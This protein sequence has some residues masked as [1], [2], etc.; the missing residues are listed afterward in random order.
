MPTEVGALRGR[1]P[2]PRRFYARGALAL[3][4]DLLGKVLVH[5]SPEGVVAGRIVE[6]EAYCGPGDRAAHTAGGRRTPRNEVMWGPPGRLYV[7]FVY[8]MHWC[9]NVVAAPEGCP[10]AV[11]LRALEPVEGAELMR[12]RRGP[13]VADRDLLRGPANLCE[14]L[15]ISGRMN[16]ADLVR[17][18]IVLVDGARRPG[19][20]V[21][22]ARRIGVDYAG[23][24][25]KRLWRFLIAG[26]GFV[27]KPPRA[28][29]AAPAPKRKKRK[30]R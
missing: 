18:K 1:R 26:S 30:G 29:S 9:A 8:G 21:A 11:L 10:E 28:G 23:A 25:A 4:P 20:R 24:H 7:Y 22:R 14:G 6:V 2:L 13:R 27:S 17:S 12:A 15:G 16:G 19:E 5:R 3:A